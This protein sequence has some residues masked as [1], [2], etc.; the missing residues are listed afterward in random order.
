MDTLRFYYRHHYLQLTDSQQL[1]LER[2]FGI[3]R[4]LTNHLLNHVRHLQHI[5]GSPVSLDYASC[6]T[7]IARLITEQSFIRYQDIAPEILRGIIVTFLSEWDD[8]QEKRIKTFNFR[9]HRDDQYLW[10]LDS[11]LIQLTDTRLTLKGFEHQP[12]TVLPSRVIVPKRCTA[13]V[14]RKLAPQQYSFTSLHERVCE[15]PHV[16]QDP[17]TRHLG[18]KLL[19]TERELRAYKAQVEHQ[20]NAQQS[21]RIH[22]DE[23]QCRMIRKVILHRL[24]RTRDERYQTYLESVEPTV[25]EPSTLA[26]YPLFHLAA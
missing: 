24:L 22:E 14:F 26:K 18:K 9:N 20:P 23:D 7:L 25:P 1:M 16:E 6:E 3:A 21:H 5:Q 12:F 8:H 11:S 10:I 2:M 19:T 15:T 17:I 4:I 13:V